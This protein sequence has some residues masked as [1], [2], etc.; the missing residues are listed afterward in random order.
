MPLATITIKNNPATISGP[1]KSPHGKDVIGISAQAKINRQDFGISWN[2]VMD[3][4]GLV[5]GDEVQLLIGVE[6]NK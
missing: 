3:N 2:K 6:A 4:G 5:V 1:V